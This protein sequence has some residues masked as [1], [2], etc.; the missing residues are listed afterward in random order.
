MNFN[1]DQ[2][3][4]DISSHVSKKLSLKHRRDVDWCSSHF[5]LYSNHQMVGAIPNWPLNPLVLDRCLLTKQIFFLFLDMKNQHFVSQYYKNFVL[6]TAGVNL[7]FPIKFG[8][9]KKKNP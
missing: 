1:N 3:Y 6:N 9:R 4:L 8:N 5:Q 2:C 7:F